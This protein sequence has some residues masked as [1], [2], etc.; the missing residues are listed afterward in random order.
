MTNDQIPDKEVMLP[1]Y[2]AG[3]VDY[4]SVTECIVNR[5]TIQSC[6][7]SFINGNCSKGR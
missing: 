5:C 1:D 2:S 6:E 7:R 3:I 4:H